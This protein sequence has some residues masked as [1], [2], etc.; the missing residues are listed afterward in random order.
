[1]N[2]GWATIRFDSVRTPLSCYLF[3]ESDCVVDFLA[4][5]DPELED[6]VRVMVKAMARKLDLARQQQIHFRIR[7]DHVEEHSRPPLQ[8][9]LNRLAK[10][11][12][13]RRSRV[14]YG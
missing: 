8:E 4:A 7:P 14:S 1:M 2:P 12:G 6:R 5:P 11:L 10:S 13:F 3:E 9:R